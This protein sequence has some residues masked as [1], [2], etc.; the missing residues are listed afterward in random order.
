MSAVV[1][2]RKLHEYGDSY[3]GMCCGA[4]VLMSDGSGDQ[5]GLPYADPVHRKPT[6]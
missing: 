1:M 5:C 6:P 3:S 4:L 2:M